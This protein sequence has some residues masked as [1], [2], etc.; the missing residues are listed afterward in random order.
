M[1]KVK[2]SKEYLAF[3]E[4]KVEERNKLKKELDVLRG[5]YK[6]EMIAG[7][8]TSKEWDEYASYIA[9][10]WVKLPKEERVNELLFAHVMKHRTING[11]SAFSGFID[12]LEEFK[13][14]EEDIE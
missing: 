4:E 8:L 5:I 11:R 13:K 1:A 2:I 6:Y 7:S 10:G 12:E 9:N 14:N 3:L